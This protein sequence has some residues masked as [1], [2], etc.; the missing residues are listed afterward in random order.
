M[1]DLKSSSGTREFRK[2]AQ[3]EMEIGKQ[4]KLWI[5]ELVV[6]YHRMHFNVKKFFPNAKFDVIDCSNQHPNERGKGCP[7]CVPVEKLW[8]VWK[9]VKSR[10]DSD[11]K[12]NQEQLKD[13]QAKINL[14]VSEEI[15]VNAIQIDDEQEQFYAVR[16]TRVQGLKIEQIVETARKREKKPISGIQDLVWFYTK[17]MSDKKKVDYSLMNVDSPELEKQAKSLYSRLSDLRARDY[18]SGGEVD[19]EDC[20]IRKRTPAQIKALLEGGEIEEDVD[21]NTSHKHDDPTVIIDDSENLSLDELDGK[22]EIQSEKT[23]DIGMDDLELDSVES[24][25][26]EPELPTMKKITP[27]ILKSNTKNKEFVD[28]INA[29]F[30]KSKLIADSGKLNSNIQLI[31]NLLKE[32]KEIEVP[33]VEFSGIPF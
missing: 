32:K 33:E 14:I 16:F 17:T 23:E 10:K 31:F 20:V 30:L 27:D 12:A 9:I 6:C 21:S 18:E 11:S 15:Y 4:Y 5:P 28:A 24:L 13:I 2:I 1:S 19:L 7:I 25:E 22:S 26:L 3:K 8:N 29:F